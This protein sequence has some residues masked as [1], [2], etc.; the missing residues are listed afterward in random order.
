[1]L[2]TDR[3]VIRALVFV[4]VSMPLCAVVG[5]GGLAIMEVAGNDT[6]QTTLIS[7]VGAMSIVI[8]VPL[9]L[10]LPE[11]VVSRVEARV[12]RNDEQQ[13]KKRES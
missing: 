13:K 3:F 7:S 5:L 12:T 4:F 2:R 1:M 6:W 8:V 11:F 9:V 10:Y